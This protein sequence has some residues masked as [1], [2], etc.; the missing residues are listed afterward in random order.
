[1]V[2]PND[3]RRTFG[4]WCGLHTRAA[5]QCD[6]YACPERVYGR[7]DV[8]QLGA[9]L[10]RVYATLELPAITLVRRSRTVITV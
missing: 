6:P 1:M 5:R 4:T 10:G 9:E 3:L 7:L 8:R 2:S